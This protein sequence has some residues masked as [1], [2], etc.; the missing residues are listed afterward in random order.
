LTTVRR[1][2][3]TWCVDS[4]SYTVAAPVTAPLS[5]APTGTAS[6]HRERCLPADLSIRLRRPGS[7]C[8]LDLR[9]GCAS[10]SVVCRPGTPRPACRESADPVHPGAT[11]APWTRDCGGNAGGDGRRCTS[12]AGERPARGLVGWQRTRGRAIRVDSDRGTYRFRHGW[13]WI[14]RSAAQNQSRR[15]DH[16]ARALTSAQVSGD[17]GEKGAEEGTCDGQP[18]V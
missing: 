16:A 18:S 15:H 2:C 10:W 6:L 17:F 1:W 3:R 13:H 7:T 14:L 5:A 11:H 9:R 4:T 8:Q 12:S